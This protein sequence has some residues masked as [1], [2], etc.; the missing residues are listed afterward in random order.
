MEIVLRCALE[1][2]PG[3]LAALAGA[4]A[5]TGG[6]IQ[7]VEVLD[8]D[9]G[10]VLDDL[11]VDIE[12]AA[13]RALV[14]RLAA[15]AGVELVHAGPSR[16]DAADAVSRLAIG[17]EALIVG[18]MPPERAVVTLI[19]GLLRATGVTVMP[20]RD[21]PRPGRR[22][23][24]LP[25]ERPGAAPPEAL[26]VRRDYPF[27]RTERERAKTVMRACRAAAEQTAALGEATGRPA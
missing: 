16:G 15:M 5:E 9:A 4:V 23:L 6:D 18:T 20:A 3:A 25:V 14:E 2:R 12:P 21:V 24:V 8:R 11:V 19:G 13:M 17:F 10:S 26:V 22:T 27:T 1:D 7:S